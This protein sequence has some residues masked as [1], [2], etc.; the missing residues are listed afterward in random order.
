M[1]PD[2][3]FQIP[4][5]KTGKI[6]QKQYRLLS[7]NVN[8][9]RAVQKKGF[10]ECLQKEQP[11][12]LAVQETKASPE[13]LNDE[14]LKPSGYHAAWNSAQR[15]GYSGVAVFSKEKP[16]NIQC[17]LG[18]EKFDIEGR[19][20]QIEFKKFILFDIYFPNGGMNEERLNYKIDFYREFFKV[21]KNLKTK[22]P[23]L[24]CGDFNTAHTEIDLARPKE[25]SK[26]SG[27]LLEERILLD[28]FVDMGYVDTFREFESE[29]GH[30]SWWDYKTKARERD[31]GWRIDH[32]FINKQS[33]KY[34]KDAFIKKDIYGSDHCPVGIQ[35]K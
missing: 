14:L 22:K 5:Y 35:L 8:G 26:V 1:I 24:I 11:F 28:E 21:I 13:Q 7:W 3:R 10:L 31:V 20:L 29:G 12:V 19:V 2:P 27:F 15:K 34:L 32:F 23:V 33:L 16:L 18:V 17:G 25:N 6:V 9:I 30:Y 4:N